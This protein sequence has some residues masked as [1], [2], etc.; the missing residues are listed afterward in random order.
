M[1]KLSEKTR[2]GDLFLFCHCEQLCQLAWGGG[3]EGGPHSTWNTELWFLIKPQAIV[4]KKLYNHVRKAANLKD[5]ERG[6][7]V[8]PRCVSPPP[9][10]PP[11][12]DS[13]YSMRICCYVLL[14]RAGL[15]GTLVRLHRRC[16]PCKS[17]LRSQRFLE[18]KIVFNRRVLWRSCKRVRP[19]LK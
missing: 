8:A 18:T 12:T 10:P 3:Q 19:L 7:H 1:E 17:V 2:E 15:L 14:E 4:N 16:T 6:L 5:F 13:V 11:L 9:P